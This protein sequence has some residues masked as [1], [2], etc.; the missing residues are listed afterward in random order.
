MHSEGH[1]FESPALCK[2]NVHA[3]VHLE[4]QGWRGRDT[5]TCLIES[6]C[7]LVWMGE[8][9]GSPPLDEELPAIKDVERGRINLPHGWPPIMVVKSQMLSL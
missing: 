1:E 3:N 2:L 5:Q 4:F 7:M 6:I 9:Y 8:S